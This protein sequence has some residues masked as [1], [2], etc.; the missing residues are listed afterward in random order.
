VKTY[1]QKTDRHSPVDQ[2]HLGG[3]V[4]GQISLSCSMRL[5]FGAAHGPMVPRHPPGVF[6][7]QC[8]EFSNKI[9][10]IQRQ[11]ATIAPAI[12]GKS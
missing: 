7:E 3:G 8:H 12:A 9:N 4:V 10:E 2:R 1:K 6:K 11:S 5:K